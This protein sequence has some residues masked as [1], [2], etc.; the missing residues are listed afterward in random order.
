M[1][2]SLTGVSKMASNKKPG[3]KS[4][5]TDPSNKKPRG[6]MI[7]ITAL[8]SK[9]DSKGNTYLVGY[10]GNARLLIFKNTYK[11]EEKHPDYRMLI[12]PKGEK[13][14]GDDPLTDE[15]GL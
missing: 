4:N 7:E 8:W 1:I 3:N 9:K 13:Q 12:A 2:Y 11:K 15:Q 5:A 14:S 6:D 10:F